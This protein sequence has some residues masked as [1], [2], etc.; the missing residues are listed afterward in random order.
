MDLQNRN[1]KKNSS[2]INDEVQK[3]LRKNG[4]ISSSDF[5]K[6]KEK[7]G[8]DDL[9][10]SIQDIYAEKYTHITK[11]AK[12]FAELIRQK[13]GNSQTPFHILLEKAIKY[14]VKYGLT[15]DEFAEFQR[16]YEQVLVG[17]K[18]TDII[19]PKTNIMKVLGGITFDYNGFKNKLNDDDYKYLQEILKL[20]A[21]SKPLHAQVLLQSMQYTDCAVESL[22]GGYN[23]D[24]NRIGDHVHPV[25]AALF[26]P[27]FRI[28]DD[29]FLWSN[30]CGIVKSRYNNE[31]LHSRPD[32]ELFHALT[33]DPNDIVC[34]NRSPILDLLNRSQLQSQ[35]WNSVLHL[36]NGQYYNASFKDFISSV[37]LC[38]LNKQ[39]TPDLL[40]GRFD[41]I[42]IKRL[43]SAFSF[44]PTIVAT[45]P[46][47]L[48]SVSLNPY[49]LNNKP[50]VTAVPMINMRLPPKL[51]NN[52][53]VIQLQDAVEQT[54]FFLENGQIVPRNTSLIWSRGILIFYVDR[55]ANTIT[56]NE[57]LTRINMNIL[58]ASLSVSGGFERINKSKVIVNTALQFNNEDYELRSVVISETN[59]N[60]TTNNNDLIIG[61][62]TLIR[63]PPDGI[64]TFSAAYYYY[65]PYAPNKQNNSPITS[66]NY[67]DPI[68][69]LSFI[70]MAQE[71][72]I[73]FIYGN[74]SAAIDEKKDLVF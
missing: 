55:R 4:K 21:T 31:P 10:D 50:L 66:I 41:G 40:Y 53:T 56:Y 46:L 19:R 61:S 6:L 1:E 7:Y 14:K 29:F 65:D 37:D 49:L 47:L 45:T 67:T 27:K 73:V 3:L 39:D 15:D 54:Q 32:Y 35:L 2:S 16:I 42:I 69:E 18:S 70:H 9:V 60:N 11:K 62:S 12:K 25:I 34:D 26:L 28:V 71:V 51:L 24:L 30:I 5:I 43:L 20:H 44:R 17:N 36:R 64:T 13:Y 63:D 74:K 68:N 52:T 57:Q 59:Q 23:R 38:R 72:G 22:S 58:P 48:T 33:T 8:D